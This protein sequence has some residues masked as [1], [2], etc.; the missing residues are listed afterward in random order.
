MATPSQ[1]FELIQ[2]NVFQDIAKLIPSSIDTT[3]AI[4]RDKPHHIAWQ[5]TMTQDGLSILRTITVSEIDLN[6]NFTVTMEEALKEPH[7]VTNT[8]TWTYN[9][10]QFDN[11][12]YMYTRMLS[13]VCGLIKSERFPTPENIAN[14][15]EINRWSGSFRATLHYVSDEFGEWWKIRLFDPKTQ[16]IYVENLPTTIDGATCS[17]MYHLYNTAFEKGRIHGINVLAERMASEEAGRA[18]N[19]SLLR[20]YDIRPALREFVHCGNLEH[21]VL[22]TQKSKKK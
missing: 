20:D 3:V 17:T 13:F 12:Q 15:S 5:F 14:L 9:A 11:M 7:F 4:N 1:H 21:A 22:S 2:S 6:D 18:L 16:E 10:E 8:D 19:A